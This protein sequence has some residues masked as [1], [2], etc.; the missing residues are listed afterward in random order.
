[1]NP[2]VD[3][4]YPRLTIPEVQ[5]ESDAVAYLNFCWKPP[6]HLGG[7]DENRVGYKVILEPVNASHDGKTQ[8]TTNYSQSDDGRICY[9]GT[10]SNFVDELKSYESS[11]CNGAYKNNLMFMLINIKVLAVV[12][13][14]NGQ[15]QSSLATQFPE[16]SVVSCECKHMHTHAHIHTRTHTHACTHTHM[17]TH[18]RTRT[19]H[20]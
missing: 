16:T 3:L 17:H 10:F 18:T 2:V 8:P 1:M 11:F 4:E 19:Q 14:T 5:N 13:L 9:T 7:L 6:S 20:T 12:N 15:N